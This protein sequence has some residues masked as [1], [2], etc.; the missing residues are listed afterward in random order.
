VLFA[1][2]SATMLLLG[3]PF[4]AWLHWSGARGWSDAMLL[5][6][7]MAFAAA[8]A[9]TGHARPYFERAGAFYLDYWRVILLTQRMTTAEWTLWLMQVALA[10]LVG[11]IVGLVVWKV[12]YR[13][14]SS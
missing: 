4:W 10:G 7:T 1:A 8:A 13:Y 6:G 11:A 9:I 12:A 3:V 5:G 2:V 14:A